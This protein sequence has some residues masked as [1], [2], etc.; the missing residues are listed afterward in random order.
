MPQGD[1]WAPFLR[2]ASRVK[3]ILLT[4]TLLYGHTDPNALANQL[5][6]L[7]MCLPT[8]A[9]PFTNLVHLDIGKFPLYCIIHMPV[10]FGPK[11]ARVTLRFACDTLRSSVLLVPLSHSCPEIRT[12]YIQVLDREA[13]PLLARFP[14]LQEIA[15]DVQLLPS[16]MLKLATSHH[17]QMLSVQLSDFSGFNNARAAETFAS[18]LNLDLSIDVPDVAPLQFLRSV[19]SKELHT[20]SMTWRQHLPLPPVM[21]RL[22]GTIAKFSNLQDL[23]FEGAMDFDNGGFT[24]L[25]LLPLRRLRRLCIYHD[26][27]VLRNCD[28]PELGQAWPE[29]A[30]FYLDSNSAARSPP[31]ITFEAVAHFAAH[32][33]K[34]TVLTV[35]LDATIIPDEDAA[36]VR[37]EVPIYLSLED[38]KIDEL[39]WPKV[40]A[41][42]SGVYPNATVSTMRLAEDEAEWED[43]RY[44]VD[45]ARMVPIISQAR[46]DERYRV[47]QAM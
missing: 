12:L 23:Q 40:A 13:S 39:C 33:P 16:T 38:S 4:S 47:L 30:E 14:K 24:L 7:Q 28:V 43:E 27:F 11:L 25:P 15:S 35:P 45:V 34:L 31:Q 2:K 1:E 19:K 22:L 42:I 36:L 21:S 5:Q 8:A 44:W 37:S 18:L 29:L 10:L 26:G 3:R 46:R 9:S 41:Y 17:L 20:L 6:T 32:F